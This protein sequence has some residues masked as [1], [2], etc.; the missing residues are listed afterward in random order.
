MLAGNS[1]MIRLDFRPVVGRLMS[2]F[3]ATTKWR[4]APIAFEIT[5]QRNRPVDTPMR[6]DWEPLTMTYLVGLFHQSV[7]MLP[8]DAYNKL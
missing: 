4:P 8:T 6:Y 1:Q 2:H 5:L 3:G 7:F